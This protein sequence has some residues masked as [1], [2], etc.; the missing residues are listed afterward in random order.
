VTSEGI[1]RCASFD[2]FVFFELENVEVVIKDV[3]LLEL[4]AVNVI[5]DV[6][7]YLDD[8]V[9]VIDVPIYKSVHT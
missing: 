6:I 4:L 3:I 9:V 1:K 5:N 8:I 7:S 2:R